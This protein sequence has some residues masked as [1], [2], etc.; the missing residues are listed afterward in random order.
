MAERHLDRGRPDRDPRIAHR[1]SD[2]GHRFAEAP[3][4]PPCRVGVGGDAD[5]AETGVAELGEVCHGHV[6]APLV[7]HDD[8]SVDAGGAA[9]HEDQRHAAFRE[10]ADEMVIDRRE[11]H[12]QAVDASVG[13][14]PRV[15]LR[16]RRRIERLERLRLDDDHEFAG[17]RSRGLDAMG[18]L[19]E[20]H[21]LQ[22]RD[23]HPDRVGAARAQAARERVRSIAERARGREDA[24]ARV[25]PDDLTR[26]AAQDSRHGRRIDLRESRDI[27][28]RRHVRC[29]P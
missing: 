28:E 9:V 14:E 22:A 2:P 13:D 3:F 15:R 21:V 11:R 25:R 24:L 20:P 23:D 12:D 18:D 16:D 26:V 5:V 4:A 10:L 8:R 19:A 17:G 6:A 7:V 29:L 27:L 1:E